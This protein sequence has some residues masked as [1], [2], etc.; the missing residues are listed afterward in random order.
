[1][2]FLAYLHSTAGEGTVS[3]EF[4]QES[5]RNFESVASAVYFP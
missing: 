1:M 4:G 2:P 5:D 3:Q